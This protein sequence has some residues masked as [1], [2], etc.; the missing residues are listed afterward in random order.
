LNTTR[1]GYV[2]PQAWQAMATFMQSQGLLSG[3]ALSGQ[4]LS[5]QYLPPALPATP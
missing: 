4:S 3:K 2:D 1:P 5:D